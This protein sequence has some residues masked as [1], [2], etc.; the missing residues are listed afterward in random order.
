MSLLEKLVRSQR[1]R[2][3]F[4]I[5]LTLKQE[6][7]NI[8]A[9]SR[10]IGATYEST[11]HAIELLKKWNLINEKKVPGFTPAREISLTDLGIELAQYIDQAENLLKKYQNGNKMKKSKE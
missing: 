7:K 3:S 1:P 2:P 4:R 5:L 10:E 6:P 8:H 11:T 9:L